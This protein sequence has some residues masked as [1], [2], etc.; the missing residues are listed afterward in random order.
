MSRRHLGAQQQVRDN[1]LAREPPGQAVK[2]LLPDDVR[3]L[4][5]LVSDR[6][7]ATSR[8]WCAHLHLADDGE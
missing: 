7:W 4:A 2:R 3:H 8:A 5:A 6:K 1:E